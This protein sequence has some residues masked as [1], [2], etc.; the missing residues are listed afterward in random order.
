MVS[1][2]LLSLVEDLCTTV[3][4]LHR[5]RM[6]LHGSLDEPAPRDRRGRAGRDARRP[7]LPA[8]RGDE[9][10]DPA[11]RP[12]RRPDP[13]WTARSGSCS[14]SGSGP[15]SAAGA[16]ALRT[17][18]G[19]LLAVVGV[20]RLPAVVAS[21]VFAPRVLIAAQLELIRRYGPLALL[22]YCV[23][24]V[25]LSSGDRSVYYSPAEVNFLFRGP[26]P[27]PAVVALQGRRRASA[28]ALVTALADGVRVRAPR[29]AVRRG[30]RRALPRARADLPVLARRRPGRRARSGR[31]RTAGGAGSC[32]LALGL[33]R[34][35]GAL[36]GRPGGA[37]PAVL[38][39][40]RA[41]AAVAGR[42][43]PCSRR[44]G[45][46][47]WRSRP[48][49]S[50]PTW[51]SGRPLAALVDLALLALVLALNAG[52]L[53]ASA[54][55]SAR[56]PRTAPAGAAGATLWAGRRRPGSRLPMLP[57]WGGSGRTSGG[58]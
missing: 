53:E 5:G 44:S 46:S 45:R 57:W 33:A 24:N 17:L 29:G 41:G 11:G 47:S 31:S 50:G 30:V 27:A 13:P 34:G 28:A 54:A 19:L 55:A 49:G 20:A 12:G 56:R 23:L 26:L 3:L 14:G 40:R 18:K 4:I 2:H 10:A 35:R 39:G 1:S 16:G 15:G 51:S 22:A 21:F 43:R 7:V 25:L 42:S 58:S 8:H 38:G 48:S 32:S 52:F 36:A 9:R 6:L 37:G